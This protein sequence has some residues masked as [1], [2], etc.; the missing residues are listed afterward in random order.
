MV[1]YTKREYSALELSLII[2]GSVFGSCLL[3]TAL[4]AYF[5]LKRI[6]KASKIIDSGRGDENKPREERAATDSHLVRSVDYSNEN[7]LTQDN[8][9]DKTM[10]Q[11]AGK[12]GKG[13][14]LP[15]IWL[16]CY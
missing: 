2:V 16:N 8:N 3:I 13:S 6:K 12:S 14:K 9:V 5:Y 15:P 11:Q 7:M 10:P 4:V 1:A